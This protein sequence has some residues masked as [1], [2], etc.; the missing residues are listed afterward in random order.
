MATAEIDRLEIEVDA[1]ASQAVQHIKDLSSV[2]TGMKKSA[3]NA[4]TGLS[5][6]VQQLKNVQNTGSSASKSLQVV[7][8]ALG[9]I[10]FRQVVRFLGDAVTSI[11]DY[12]E[13]VNLF[14]VSM[15]EYYDEA[16]A[17]AELVNEKMGIDTAQWMDAQGT[18]ALMAKGFGI[19]SG[20]AYELSESLTELAYDIS[21]LKNK[22]P[23]EV[24]NKLRSALA[25]ELEPI[26]EL[27]LS[28][29]QATLQE[30]ALSKG[31]NE[32][33][34]SMTEQ[35][36]AL[37][38]SV[39]VLEDS[40]RIEY[41]GDFAKTLESPANAMRVLNQQ[42]TQ[43]K[44]AIGSVML[45][46]IIQILPYIQAF[47]S[48]LTDA[49]SAFATFV[50]F[51]MPEWDGESWNTAADSVNDTTDAVKALKR[52]VMGIDEL[53][54]LSDNN[55]SNTASGVSDWANDLEIPDLWDKAAIAEIETKANEIKERI[56]PLV[57]TVGA[58]AAGFLAWKIGS[59][60]FD[61]IAKLKTAISGLEGNKALTI[62]VTLALAG[63]AIEWDAILDTWENGMDWGNLAEMTV[64]EGFTITGGY[65]IGTKF[66]NGLMGGAIA[67]IIASGPALGTAVWD[68][69]KNGLNDKNAAAIALN[70]VT[71][72]ASIGALFG[73]GGAIAGAFLGGA[74]GLMTIL[75]IRFSEDWEGIKLEFITSA[76]SIPEEWDNLCNAVNESLTWMYDSVTGWWNNLW[77]NIENEF[78]QAKTAWDEDWEELGAA[79]EDMWNGAVTFFTESV[80]AWFSEVI[81][82]WFTAE[83]WKELGQRAIDGLSGGISKSWDDLKKWWSD[84]S[85]PEFKIKMPHISWTSTE[86]KGWIAKT[87]EAIG[88][89]SS[90]PK[91]NVEWYANGGFPD[92]GQMFIARESGPELVGRIG[93]R[94]AVANNDQIVAGIAQGVS[95]ANENVVNAIYA[96]AQ[97]I[98]RAVDEQGGDIYLDYDKVG[99]KMTQYAS[100]YARARG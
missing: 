2:L 61:D 55:S 49:I 62:G 27:G 47:V 58:I 83:K 17:Y 38:R 71:L 91:M 28:I 34:A 76:Q 3:Q 87:L 19:A 67:G 7:K 89:P 92:H 63:L 88:L 14:Q 48:L 16:F 68:A 79:A 98:V 39:K 6:V 10:G 1:A 11:N 40:R 20:Q 12:V 96:M 95:N 51:T 100:N 97:Q 54:I 29:S 70:G 26:R 81:E 85:L 64:G 77:T 37:L 73:P 36:K 72:G 43:F 69:I 78:S 46:A 80:P 21:S 74:A 8:T 5:G 45:P 42:I 33:V 31:I 82:P 86:A 56:E 99:R 44:R 75:G 90:I 93:S 57:K 13:G 25:G 60:I 52:Q 35:E 32:S 41:V 22:K 53:N 15:G 4:T 18:F 9:A 84:L 66:G 94:T 50:G 23:E 65:L 24:V 59:S 30:Y